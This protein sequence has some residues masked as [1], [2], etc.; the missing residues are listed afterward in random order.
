MVEFAINSAQSKSTTF[1]PFELNY[2]YIPTLRGLL[3]EVPTEY[4][5]GIRSYAARARTNIMEAHDAI[6]AAR[7][8]QTFYANCQ[9]R[10]DD[11][12]SINDK[13]W[14]STENLT[15]PKGRIRKFMPRFIGPFKIIDSDPTSSN[16]QLEL[17]SEMSV[18]NIHPRF[19]ASLLRPFVDN[20]EILFPKRDAR[21]FYDY[22]EPEDTEWDVDEILGHRWEG[23]TAEFHVKWSLGDTTWEPFKHVNKAAA[24]DHY[25]AVMD[26]AD[27][28]DLPRKP[29]GARAKTANRGKAAPKRK[30]RAK[31]R[32]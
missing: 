28:K 30:G 19:H 27:W 25:L 3:A 4:K 24:L 17:P 26:V 12:Y 9:R 13:V 15:M 1:A 29:A 31:G 32:R 8:A 23:R 5:P 10:I 6:I 16:Y 22:G 2:G 7:V 14:L 11:P 18:R 21:Y 20:D